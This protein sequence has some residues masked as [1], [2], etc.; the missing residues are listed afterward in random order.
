MSIGPQ[1]SE[2]HHFLFIRAFFIAKQGPLSLFPLSPHETIVLFLRLQW[3]FCIE[4]ISPLVSL[5]NSLETRLGGRESVSSATRTTFLG[6]GTKRAMS[7]GE[8]WA[9]GRS[10]YRSPTHCFPALTMSHPFHQVL[11]GAQQGHSKWGVFTSLS[12]GSTS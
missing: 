4:Q 7:P 3:S 9:A 1:A 5:H 10:L 6:T 2:D 11:N 8:G 12:L